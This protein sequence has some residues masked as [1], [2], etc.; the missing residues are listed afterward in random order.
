M[1]G[2]ALEI[3]FFNALLAMHLKPREVEEIQDFRGPL[4]T[5][6]RLVEDIPELLIGGLDLLY[7][8]GAWYA[9]LGIACSMMMIL[10]H[11]FVGI[12]L[13]CRQSAMWVAQIGRP[14][15]TE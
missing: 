9:W 7:F 14:L 13:T 2:A 6:L 8:G 5:G 4:N 10:F 3:P 12:F 15:E 11:L 1:K